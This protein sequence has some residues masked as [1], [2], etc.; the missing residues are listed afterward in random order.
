[1]ILPPRKS[2]PMLLLSS[3]CR[4][5]KSSMSSTSWNAIP[6]LRPRSGYVGA[7]LVHHDRRDHDAAVG[8]A[9]HPVRSQIRVYDLDRRGSPSPRHSAEDGRLPERF[10]RPG[11][12]DDRCRPILEFARLSAGGG[13]A[14]KRRRCTKIPKV[15]RKSCRLGAHWAGPPV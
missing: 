6:R 9:R 15:A 12:P 2:S 7:D 13:F 10:F 14:R 4:A 1:V 8:L 5:E 11:A 3:V